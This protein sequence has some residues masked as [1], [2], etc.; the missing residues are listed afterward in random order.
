ML[1]VISRAGR[2]CHLSKMHQYLKLWR[3]SPKY[4][5][6]RLSEVDS[7]RDVHPAS[8][9]RSGS[10][11]IPQGDPATICLDGSQQPQRTTGD[12]ARPRARTRARYE[13]NG[14]ENKTVGP[15]QDHDPGD[16]AAGVT[17]ASD[18]GAAQ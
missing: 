1:R 16:T 14:A 7:P 11:R 3:D 5:P 17:C 10:S 9:V 12:V 15:R 13:T 18:R 4:G 8:P 6:L 2:P